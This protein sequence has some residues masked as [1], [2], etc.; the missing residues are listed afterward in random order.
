MGRVASS[1][2]SA[3][4][5]VSSTSEGADSFDSRTEVADVDELNRWGSTK[6]REILICVGNCLEG[7]R[8]VCIEFPFGSGVVNSVVFG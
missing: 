6:M 4:L 3:V 2:V 1:V 8:N 7:V 5:F